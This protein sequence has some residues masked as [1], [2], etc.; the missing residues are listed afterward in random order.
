VGFRVLTLPMTKLTG[1]PD[2]AEDPRRFDLDLLAGVRVWDV[3]A[4][5]DLDI[6]PASLTVGGSQVPLPGITRDLVYRLKGITLPGNVLDGS[7]RTFEESTSWA[8]PI[9]GFRASADVWKGLSVFLLGD[10]GGWG[11]GAASDLTWQGMLGAR[12]DWS[13][14]WGVAGGYRALGVNRDTGI[15]GILY[16]PQIGVV[17]RY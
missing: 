14:H 8:D 10:I 7:Q 1:A 12:Y 15:D 11:I 6:T 4:K 17:F 5:T 9:V 2:D 16:G 3:S 13:E